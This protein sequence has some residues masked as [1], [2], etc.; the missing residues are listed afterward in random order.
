MRRLKTY[1]RST[2]VSE[3]LN[4]IALMHFHQETVSDIEIVIY[5]FS[6]KN[7]RLTFT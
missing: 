7:R 1:V 3:R 2:M 4:G 5:L 6:T